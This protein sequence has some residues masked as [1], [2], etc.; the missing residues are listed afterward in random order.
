MCNMTWAASPWFPLLSEMHF[1]SPASHPNLKRIHSLPFVTILTPFQKWISHRQSI[2][3]LISEAEVFFA[4]CSY[5]RNM[6]NISF[7][8]QWPTKPDVCPL[9]EGFC[10]LVGVWAIIRVDPSIPSACLP[11]LIHSFKSPSEESK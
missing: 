7:Q 2:L 1:P 6:V 4:E 5:L 9:G 11:G 3:K 8:Q 10:G